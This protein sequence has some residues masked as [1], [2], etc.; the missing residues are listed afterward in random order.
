MVVRGLACAGAGDVAHGIA[1]RYLAGLRRVY[2][3]CSPHTLWEC[4]APDT[5]APGLK[6]YSP[7][8]VKPDFVGWSGLGPISILIENVIGVDVDSPG[9]IVEWTVR[10]TDE[11]GVRGLPV[12]GGA[13][14]DLVCKERR[15]AS[16]PAS[17]HARS[18]RGI[19]LRVRRGK[20]V[21][22]RRLAAGESCSLRL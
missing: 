13:R 14:A 17:L 22:E 8:R 9:G 5:D 15:T 11:H 21:D 12:G 10:R 1:T 6:P 18:Q 7:D 2:D 20:Q 19:L 16:E 4:C 3:S